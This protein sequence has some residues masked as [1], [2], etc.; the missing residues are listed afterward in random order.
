MKILRYEKAGEKIDP[1]RSLLP[2]LKLL[3]ETTPNSQIFIDKLIFIGEGRTQLD[4]SAIN[5]SGG[6]I[7]LLNTGEVH[8]IKNIDVKIESLSKAGQ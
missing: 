7:G 3:H 6:N 2:T 1:F 5:I 4:L 8:H